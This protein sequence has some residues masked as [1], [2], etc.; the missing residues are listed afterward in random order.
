LDE[1]RLA[2]WFA[3]HLPE[4]GGPMILRQFRGGQ[5]NPTFWLGTP[6]GQYVLRKKPPGTLLPS[7]HAVEREYRVMRALQGTEVPVAKVFGLCEDP[8]VIGTPF[9][10]MQYVRGRIFW[11]VRLPDEV[12]AARAAIY[13]ELARVIAA[14]HTL[15]VDAAGLADYGRPGAYV[16]RQTRRWSKQYLA[17]AT[18]SIPTMDAL[19]GW[20]PE[21]QPADDASTLCH[22][23]YRL[24]NLIFHPTEPRII[25]VIDWELSTL[26]HPLADLAYTCMI[27]DVDLPHMGGLKDVDFEGSGILS[28]SSFLER[29]AALTGRPAVT[30][31][32]YYKAFSLFRLAAICQG[33]YQ[34][35]LQGNASSE[36]ATRFGEAVH[37]L[38][39]AACQLVDLR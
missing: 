16:A 18:D 5:S 10:V 9:F 37:M 8:S 27:Y 19:M 1:G 6:D 7:A 38:S 4:I 22:G 31:W 21:H 29:Y 2:T 11:D 23:D 24:D 15:D 12:P 33:V 39:E 28:E 14:L 34:R 17:S 20:L 25:A 26:G 30:D 36:E 13:A 35:G 3:A 32:A